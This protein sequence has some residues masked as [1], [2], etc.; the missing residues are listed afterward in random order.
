M[1]GGQVALQMPEDWG[2]LQNT[3]DDEDNYVQV[4]SSGGTLGDWD[5]TDDIVEL[6]SLRLMKGIPSDSL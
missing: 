3:D 4:T 2:D 5:V 1:N 6:T